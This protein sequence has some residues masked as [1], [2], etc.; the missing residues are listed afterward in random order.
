MTLA[1]W[2]SHYEVPASVC[3]IRQ[4]SKFPPTYKLRQKCSSCTCSAAQR[5]FRHF[6]MLM[7]HPDDGASLMPVTK[8]RGA[9]GCVAGSLTT[10]LSLEAFVKTHNADDHPFVDAAAYHLDIVACL[11]LERNSAAFHPQNRSGCGHPEPDWGR[12]DMTNIEV[13]A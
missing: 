10:H 7:R 6:G 3:I 11:H 1:H 4:F 12:G 13:N 9:H 8:S 2:R 5:I